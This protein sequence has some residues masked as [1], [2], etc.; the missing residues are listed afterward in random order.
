VRVRDD[1]TRAKVIVPFYALYWLVVI[2]CRY[3]SRQESRAPNTPTHLLPFCV[4]MC[5]LARFSP[6]RR[7]LLSRRACAALRD[8]WELVY[9]CHV[10]ADVSWPT[11]RSP[12]LLPAVCVARAGRRKEAGKG[13]EEA[14][15]TELSITNQGHSQTQIGAVLDG[16]PNRQHAS[17]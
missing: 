13:R 9:G 15:A 2:G 6:E 10:P 7:P 12:A 3:F 8:Y 1:A 16:A 4:R 5:P 11:V 14:D 17:E